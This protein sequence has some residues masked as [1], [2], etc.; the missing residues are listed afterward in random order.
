MIANGPGGGGRRRNAHYESDAELL[1]SPLTAALVASA[2]PSLARLLLHPDTFGGGGQTGSGGRQGP[3]KYR[4]LGA[5]KATLMR[6]A[7][8][9][10]GPIETFVMRGGRFPIAAWISVS[11]A[12]API[13]GAPT[14]GGC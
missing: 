6:L 2:P 14:A 9:P 4:F 8:Q 11:V 1:R 3:T 13:A 12:V 7:A 5:V 10:P